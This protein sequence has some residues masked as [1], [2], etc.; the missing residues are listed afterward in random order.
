MIDDLRRHFARELHD[1]VAQ[2]LIELVLRIRNLR[3][4]TEGKS[5]LTDELAELEESTR[6]VL[7]KTREMMIDAR[8]RG[9]LRINLEQAL[10]NELRVAPGQNLVIHVSSRWPAQ[11]NGW[12][13]F[14]VLRVVQQAVANARGHGRA[15]KIEVVLDVG[16][17]GD[18]VVV[19]VDDG[20]GIQDAAAGFGMQGM[21]ERAA[22]L[23]GT[24]SAHTRDSG[25]TRVEVRMPADRLR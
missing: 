10:K 12:A 13:A 25:G 7:R 3:T 24:F 5:D 18:A 22:I 2:P 4:E 16:P 19:V 14:N 1:Q 11:T 15:Q 21:R 8:E 17:T 23:G 6:A 9:E 20:I